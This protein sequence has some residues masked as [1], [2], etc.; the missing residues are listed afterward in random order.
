MILTRLTSNE[1][2]LHQQSFSKSRNAA[3]IFP[4]RLMDTKA[5]IT[6]ARATNLEQNLLCFTRRTGLMVNFS[7]S[8]SS[9]AEDQG[10]T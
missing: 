5:I 4:K 10:S 8:F 7:V 1:Q 3:A 6:P 2:S 9:L